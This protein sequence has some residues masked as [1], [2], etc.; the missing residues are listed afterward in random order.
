[1]LAHRLSCPVNTVL[2]LMNWGVSRKIRAQHF[3]C[4]C[5][6]LLLLFLLLFT[7]ILQSFK[8]TLTESVGFGVT[9]WHFVH[10]QFLKL[11]RSQHTSVWLNPEIFMCIRTLAF[12]GCV[13]FPFWPRKGFF[14]RRCCRWHSR[15]AKRT[16][17]RH[18]LSQST[19]VEKK[20]EGKQL[21]S[22]L[23]LIHVFWYWRYQNLQY[24]CSSFVHSSKSLA[25]SS[26]S[27]SAHKDF[28]EWRHGGKPTF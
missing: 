11:L 23:L 5:I 1:M 10:C 22:A 16:V 4:I 8:T 6:H 20:S 9:L 7:L 24:C 19:L 28:P 12:G 13:Y 2:K 3:N 25:G 14:S 18:M 21:F 15:E 27:H 26:G 17:H